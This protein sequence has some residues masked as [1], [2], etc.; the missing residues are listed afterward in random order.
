[1][2]ILFQ[3]ADAVATGVHCRLMCSSFDHCAITGDLPF[4]Q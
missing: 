3:R 4:F 2:K 1:M